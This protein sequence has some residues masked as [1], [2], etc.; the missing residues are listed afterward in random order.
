VERVLGFDQLEDAKEKLSRL[1]QKVRDFG[2]SVPEVVPLLASQFS[3]PLADP[4]LPRTVS[5]QKRRQQTL[6][7][8]AEWL[9][10][11]A[12]HEPM[13][14]VWEDLHWADPTTLELL[15]L[16][17]ERAAETETPLFS[18][19]TFRPDEFQPPWPGLSATKV[20][21]ARLERPAVEEMIMKITGGRSL[22]RK[23]VEEIVERT[24]GVPL[25]V[26]EL[27][28]TVLDS[29]S[30][31]EEADHFVIAGPS[32]PVA[33]PATLEDSL[34]SRLDRLG[35]AKPIA[36]RGAILGRTFSQDLL[37][38]V[39]DSDTQDESKRAEAWRRSKRCLTQLVEA[40]ILRQKRNRQPTYEFKHS[41]IQK[42]AYESLLK[43]VR[44]KYH[45]QT[46]QVLETEFPHIAETQ[47]ELVAHH[48]SEASKHSRALDY[49][50][51]AGERARDR[52]ANK[53]AIH[54]FGEALKVLEVLPENEERYRRELV[55]R[56]ASITPLISVEGYV[57]DA[58]S[59]TAERALALCRALGDVER[60]FPVLYLLWVT[61]LV[62]A[63]YAEALRLSEDFT[64]EANNRNDSATRLM[65]HRLRGFSQFITGGLAAAQ[66]HLEHSLKLYDPKLHSEL[67]N[68]G[69]GQDPRCACEAF[70]ALVRWLRGYPD[71]EVKWSRIALEHAEQARHSNTWGYVLCF[72]GATSAVF[73]KD[74]VNARR[75]GL[76]LTTFSTQEALPVWSGYGRVLYGWA[77]AQT[78][79]ID[80]GI[81]Q[82]KTGL[83]DFEDKASNEASPGS[84]HMGFMKSFLVSLLGEGY[85][86]L[87]R[88]DEGLEQFD[89]AWSF[90][91]ASGEA[92]WKAE[93]LRLKGELL[94][95]DHKSDT[96]C[97]E[98]EVCFLKAL[99]IA[100]GQ[101]AKSL[102]LRAAISLSRL[103]REEKP[104][105][106]LEI[107]QETYDS[108][109]EG[110]DSVDLL[111][112]RRLLDQLAGNV[113]AGV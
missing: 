62:G 82:M 59:R 110:F 14:A 74:V 86:R 5:P 92:F 1:E 112:A 31:R 95:A 20:A 33:I 98:A 49:W 17:I 46:A 83:I 4:D 72:G 91:E 104:S 68:Q 90:A 97:Q 71:D 43:E 36:Q 101:G 78:P 18:L 28:Q 107:L 47:P 24:E 70:M 100:S 3:L 7:V 94:R 102:E 12:Q 75:H 32:L 65:S 13:M 16:V 51:K 99:E 38:A 29:G 61:R 50:Q 41:L 58:T 57:A 23:V 15:G 40:G 53:E 67:K 26:E 64:K 103:W 93:I 22:P 19:L 45:L 96:K 60:L 89:A 66:D 9:V 2:F 44:P 63:K 77:L 113:R 105:A 106:A 56:I 34:M 87:G 37:R 35:A 80:D 79:A 48:F 109:T 81:E 6:S 10:K 52:S 84:L 76:A 11:E 25:F 88:A 8:F 108:F 55:L 111:E 42:A 73:R 54:H 30:V 27:V 69:Y 39:L 21:L 85:V